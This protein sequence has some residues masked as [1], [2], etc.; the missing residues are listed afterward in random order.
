MKFIVSVNIAKDPTLRPALTLSTILPLSTAYTV[1]TGHLQ[2]VPASL[3][4]W[5]NFLVPTGI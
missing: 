3:M 1:K 4:Y 5:D 2:P